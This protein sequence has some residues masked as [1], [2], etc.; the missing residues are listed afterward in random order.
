MLVFVF[1]SIHTVEQYEIEINPE[2]YICKDFDYLCDY[3]RM[4]CMVKIAR[5][6]KIFLAED[7]YRE[8]YLKEVKEIKKKLK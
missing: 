7:F 8:F 2:D 1:E 3:A 5:E 6:S 4:D